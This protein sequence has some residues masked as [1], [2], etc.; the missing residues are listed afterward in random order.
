MRGKTI[1]AN[2]TYVEINNANMYDG[3]DG[4]EKR[5]TEADKA[6]RYNY[7]IIEPIDST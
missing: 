3:Y 5:A 7:C 6:N 1:T 4:Y 2:G